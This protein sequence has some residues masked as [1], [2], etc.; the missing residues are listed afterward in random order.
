MITTTCLCHQQI[1][2]QDRWTRTTL[3]RSTLS[4]LLLPVRH[5][6]SQSQCLALI[7]DTLA[8]PCARRKKRKGPMRAVLSLSIAEVKPKAI[9]RASDWAPPCQ[10]ILLQGHTSALRL[11]LTTQH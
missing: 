6:V 1:R 4:P 11:T 5:Q 10:V 2:I 3:P 9:L 7:S 8:E